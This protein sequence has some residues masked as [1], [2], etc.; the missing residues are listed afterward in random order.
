MNNLALL[1]HILDRVW[2]IDKDCLA[3]KGKDGKTILLHTDSSYA[4]RIEAALVPLD[5]CYI[6]TPDG[7]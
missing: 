2:K 6:L 4:D 1:I 3:T 7:K 5:G